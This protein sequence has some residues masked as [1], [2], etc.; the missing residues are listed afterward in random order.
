MRTV[1]VVP[2]SGLAG[3]G[4]VAGGAAIGAVIGAVIGSAWPCVVAGLGAA[5]YVAFINAYH[6]LT[7]A[8]PD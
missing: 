6:G 5:A 1:S 3:A 2:I 8:L 7:I 4:I